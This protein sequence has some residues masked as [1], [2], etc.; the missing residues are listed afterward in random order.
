MS[1]DRTKGSAKVFSKYLSLMSY[2]IVE[3]M[4]HS[5][6]NIHC[7]SNIISPMKVTAKKVF[8]VGF[9]IE[10]DQLHVQVV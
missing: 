2:E 5:T 3:S 7:G 9:M 8:L 1:G 10:I 6:I 4:L